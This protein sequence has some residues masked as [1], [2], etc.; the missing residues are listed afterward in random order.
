[1]YPSAPDIDLK[2]KKVFV[3]EEAG[4]VMASNYM[5]SLLEYLRKQKNIDILEETEVISVQN[6]KEGVNISIKF[7]GKVS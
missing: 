5:Q 7:K 4:V 2:G 1:M 6:D 3:E